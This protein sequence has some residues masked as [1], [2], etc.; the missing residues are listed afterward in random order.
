MSSCGCIKI[1][2]PDA[3]SFDRPSEA[4]STA[5]WGVTLPPINGVSLHTRTWFVHVAPDTLVEY[6]EHIVVAR[7]QDEALH[8]IPNHRMD[9]FPD[10][11][12]T[13]LIVDH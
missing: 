7:H 2:S 8:E 13:D 11:L 12:A 10:R 4:R 5:G 3:F 9:I 6:S 1:L